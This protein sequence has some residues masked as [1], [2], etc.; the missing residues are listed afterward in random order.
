MLFQNPVGLLLRS[1]IVE[2]SLHNYNTLLNCC[3]YTFFARAFSVGEEARD[4][5]PAGRP[6][7]HTYIDMRQSVKTTADV[8]AYPAC[9]P[10]SHLRP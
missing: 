8:Y 10:Q 1:E 2:G 7:M 4:S 9:A 5:I 6:P 3:L